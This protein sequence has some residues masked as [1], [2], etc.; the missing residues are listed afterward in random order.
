MNLLRGRGFQ[1][2]KK[3]IGYNT[4][5]LGI[6]LPLLQQLRR[7]GSDITSG[8]F[9]FENVNRSEDE[10]AHPS[11][12]WISLENPRLEIL[13][14]ENKDNN[15]DNEDNVVHKDNGVNGVSGVM[16]SQ[17]NGCGLVVGAGGTARAA[18]YAIKDMGL[19]LLV[20]NRSPLRAQELAKSFGGQVVTAAQVRGI[21]RLIYLEG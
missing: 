3:L 13:K 6:Q 21:R 12:V 10:D 15:D 5:W 2:N 8:H 20:Y 9:E 14:N 1:P 18:A 11:P 7:K 4:D 16:S 17:I 19:S